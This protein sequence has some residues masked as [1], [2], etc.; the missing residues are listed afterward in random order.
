MSDFTLPA[1][2]LKNH[3]MVRSYGP[4]TPIDYDQEPW[5][6]ICAENVAEMESISVD[7]ARQNIRMGAEDMADYGKPR[8]RIYTI[9]Q[10]VSSE[11]V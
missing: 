8:D 7:Q 2:E 3:P 1:D 9:P 4:D 10:T 11:G 6:R 5:L